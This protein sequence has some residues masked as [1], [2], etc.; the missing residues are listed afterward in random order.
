MSLCVQ[1][2]HPTLGPEG[3]CLYHSASHGEDWATGNRIVCDF[4]HR[5]IVPPTPRDRVG[6]SMELLLANL[7]EP[8]AA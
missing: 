2:G 8:V 6:C 7:E 5:G 3:L 4:L 1:C